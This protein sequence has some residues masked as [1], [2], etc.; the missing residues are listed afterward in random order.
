MTGKLSGQSFIFVFIRYTQHCSTPYSSTSE[1]SLAND[2]VIDK[3]FCISS[4]DALP[5]HGNSR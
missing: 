3:D 2:I 4:Q 1:V 5:V